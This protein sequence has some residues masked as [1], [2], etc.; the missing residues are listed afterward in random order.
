MQDPANTAAGGAL[1][2]GAGLNVFNV[3]TTLG[4]PS[5]PVLQVNFKVAGADLAAALARTTGFSF[6]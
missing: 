1:T 3:N 5:D 4:Y 6:N 2:A